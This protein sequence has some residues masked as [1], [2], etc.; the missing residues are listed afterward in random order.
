MKPTNFEEWVVKRFGR[1]LY[2]A[3]FRS[4]TEKVWGIPGSEI[5]A[6]WA[7][8]RIQEF[9]L[10]HAILGILG[11]NRNEP[12]TLIEEFRYPRLG[13]GQM[14][15]AFADWVEERGIPVRL[16]HRCVAIKHSGR[17]RREH[18]RRRGR[19][20][21]EPRRRRACSRASR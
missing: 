6:E 9:S 2:D 13:P 16:N 5:Q 11:L 14:W 19:G 8:Q 15:E 20:R 1:R 12:P 21:V 17:A 3:F 7:A 18:R 4:Y 10:K